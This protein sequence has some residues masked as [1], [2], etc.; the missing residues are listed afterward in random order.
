MFDF[1]GVSVLLLLVFLLGWLTRRAWR[2]RNRVAKWAGAI[3]AGI[4]TAVVGVV[5]CAALLG[6]WKLNRTRSNPIS[7]VSVAL[8]PERIARGARFEPY[9]GSCHAP[10]TGA[11][12]TGQDFLGDGA[13]PIGTFHAPNLTPVQLA[14][15]SDGEIIRA[16]REGIHRDGRSLLVMPSVVL[17]HLS[18]RDVQSIVAY[19]RS[20]PPQGSETPPNRLN[21]LGAMMAAVIPIFEAQPPITEPI[22]AP[23]VG[24]TAEYGA[25]IASLTCEM[26]HGN[27]LRGDPEF[28]A[29][30]LTGISQAWNEQQF[31]EFIRTGIRPGGVS[32][33]GDAM[34]W[35]FLSRF[36][37]DDDEVRAVY[38][39]L[40]DVAVE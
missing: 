39:H 22:I 18:D 19:L 25:Y 23:P 2:V 6:Y 10:E 36:L 3:T 20:R 28:G 21:V 37:R 4:L 26:C 27:D 24:P 5:F 13:P 1:I 12:L 33:D 16:I 14:E 7:Q 30:A 17:H 11:P 29:P 15:W 31:I 34:P 32:V 40:Q 8:T 38:A 35:E 9:C